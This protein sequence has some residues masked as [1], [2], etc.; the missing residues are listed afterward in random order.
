MYST[1]SYKA[2]E[3]SNAWLHI[4]QAVVKC[5]T[6]EGEHCGA[7][8]VRLRYAAKETSGF[9]VS[10]CTSVEIILKRAEKDKPG[11]K[12]LDKIF[13]MLE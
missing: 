4:K 7:L 8:C 5:S 1:F 12:Y 9:N 6:E 13:V 10:I 3:T 2:Q 11:E